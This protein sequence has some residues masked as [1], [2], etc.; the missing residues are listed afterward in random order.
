MSATDQ[1]PPSGD[2]RVAPD[3][4]P[5]S[6]AMPS[7]FP[8]I[9]DYG[10]L[11]DCHTGAL[12]APDG[13]IDWLCVPRFDAPS[14]FGML[15]DR[16]AGSFRFGP[17]GINVPSARIYEPG[18]N[19]LTTTWKT[20]SGWM[21]VRDALTFG[22]RTHADTVTPH[23][24]PPTDEDARH[25]LV[26]LAMCLE[27]EVELELTCEPVFDYGRVTATWSTADGDHV[28][29]ATGGDVT[30]RLRSDLPLG[31][32]GDRVRARHVLRQGEQAFCS[33]SW[34]EELAGPESV[35]EANEQ[36][37]DTARFWR[38]W[39]GKARIPDHRWRD[40]IQRSALAIKG[41]TYMPTGATV[42]ALDDLAARDARRRTQ[43]G[44]PL[45]VA[46][47]LHL[48]AAGAV[49]PEPRLGGPGVHTVHRRPGAR[50]GRR[51]CRSCT[52]STDAA[53]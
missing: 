32:E 20:P 43:L 5:Q 3:T 26:R 36:L 49:L 13:A 11:S 19:M 45:H 12:V 35:D 47:R 1:T 10:F 51:R 30:I 17:F 53:T 41:L 40:P 14:I 21:I 16:Q 33:L 15:L 37:A 9:A 8:P 44:L 24:R 6:A 31:I 39:L 52:G 23:T 7:P 50:R 46:A 29:D 25:V 22:P 28:A 27:G 38:E 42:A 4:M 34:A 2:G 48:H 18:T